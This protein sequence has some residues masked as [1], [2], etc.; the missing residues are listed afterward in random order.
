MTNPRTLPTTDE[1]LRHAGW[2]RRLAGRLVDDGA[3]DDLVQHAWLAALRHRP[4]RGKGFASWL[5]SVLHNRAASD[6]RANSR[7]RTR[8]VLHARP[9]ALP[10]TAEL[11]SRVETTR[12]LVEAV[13]RLKPMQRDVIFL[14]YFDEL[15]LS[16]IAERLG[17]PAATVRS[18][19]ARGLA[20]LR[21][22]LDAASDG[23]RAH[24]MHALAP[25]APLTT[26][27]A[28]MTVRSTALLEA[29]LMTTTHKI[30]AGLLLGL[31]VTGLFL[32]NAFGAQAPQADVLENT[33]E[34]SRPE[35]VVVEEERVPTVG[36]RKPIDGPYCLITVKHATSGKPLAGVAMTPAQS[37]H[38]VL[39]ADT[40]SAQARLSD[41]HGQLSVALGELE[42]SRG[43]FWV[44]KPGFYAQ[45]GSVSKARPQ[46]TLTLRPCIRYSIL[47]VDAE[48]KPVPAVRLSVHRGVGKAPK[49]VKLGATVREDGAAVAWAGE[50]RHDGSCVI[51]GVHIDG[52]PAYISIKSREWLSI[53]NEDWIDGLSRS[54]PSVKIQVTRVLYGVGRV[55]NAEHIAH[56][57]ERSAW[58]GATIV[59]LNRLI[60]LRRSLQRETGV[61]MVHVTLPRKGRLNSVTCKVWTAEF[62]AQD[63]SLPLRE[64]RSGQPIAITKIKVDTATPSDVGRLQI[65]LDQPSG[66]RTLSG[67]YVDLWRI[68]SEEPLSMRDVPLGKDPVVVPVG[69]YRARLSTPVWFAGVKPRLGPVKIASGKS[70]TMT[71]KSL[72]DMRKVKL[73]VTLAGGKLTYGMALRLSAGTLGSTVVTTK[74]NPIEC[75]L[76][77][78]RV[79]Y[80]FLSIRRNVVTGR[81]T[82]VVSA[83]H[84]EGDAADVQLRLPYN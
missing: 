1:L 79:Q 75:F 18:H 16:V 42:Q 24:W 48:G 9:E 74:M 62:A 34:E 50:T 53:G 31:L 6:A 61:R 72:A 67:M 45:S 11:A 23:D 59:G 40:A 49:S 8:E 32:F 14:R 63:F 73:S 80:E 65:V 78:G 77:V 2:L 41:E 82:F 56:R 36:T 84:A 25:L 7:R 60:D 12:L 22:D 64:Y 54:M 3:A 68:N 55:V 43:N 69:E 10:S 29:L 83:A 46:A 38:T 13:L 76:P 4:Q 47:V 26:K 21:Q 35:F 51:D 28:I 5:R 37:P 44:F 17:I 52:V 66:R 81:G 19:L 27:T 15:A 30:F 39:N 33:I 71:L 70:E 20:H 57:F 58:R